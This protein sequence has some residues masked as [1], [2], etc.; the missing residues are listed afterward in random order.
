MSIKKIAEHTYIAS[1]ANMAACMA[2]HGS[3]IILRK[4]R[5][6][7]GEEF[8]TVINIFDDEDEALDWL[9]GYERSI[10]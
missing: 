3:W 2:E 1:D 5:D 10:S 7:L 9:E 4:Q 6:D 8:A